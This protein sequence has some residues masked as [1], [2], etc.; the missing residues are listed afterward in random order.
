M[1]AHVTGKLLAYVVRFCT[2]TSPNGLFCA[3]AL[4]RFEDALRSPY[5]RNRQRRHDPQ[6]RG[7]TEGRR[8]P[9]ADAAL[10]RA[11]VP[12]PEPDAR[13]DA[14]GWTFWK[15]ASMRQEDEDEVRSRV[16]AHPVA[17]VF[18]EEARNG[19]DVPALIGAVAERCAIETADLEPFYRTLVERGLLVGEV[20]L[21]YNARRPLRMLAETARTAGCTPSWLGAVERIEAEVDTLQGSTAAAR[22]EAMQ[23]TTQ[24]LEALPHVRP[25]KPDDMFRADAASG[26]SVRLPRKI[27]GELREGLRPYVRMFS[28]FYPERIYRSAQAA[29]FLRT[30][31]PDTEVSLLDLYHGV[32][33]PE[34]KRRPVAFPDPGRV[35]VEGEGT[36]EAAEALARTREHFA[37]RAREAKPGEEIEITDGAMRSLVGDFPEPRWSSGVLFQLDTQD[38]N[39][40]TRGDYRLVLSALFQGTGL[41]LARFAHLHGEPVVRELKEGWSCLSRPGAVLAEMTYNHTYRTANAGLRPA[42]FEHEIE[43]PESAA[44]PARVLPLADLTVRWDTHQHGSPPARDGLEV[45]PASTAASTRW[46]LSF[47]VDI[48]CKDSSRSAFPGFEAGCHWPRVVSGTSSSSGLLGSQANG[49]PL[50]HARKTVCWRPVSGAAAMRCRA[51]CSSTLLRTPSRATWTSSLPSWSPSCCGASPRKRRPSCT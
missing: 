18:L 9:A 46:G 47:L 1:P 40:L 20:E 14:E 7:G 5:P 45:L 28:A 50:L 17:N 43:L 36:Q 37:Q 21:P 15:P 34:N 32:F 35:V 30:F 27:L 44:R 49:P 12:R 4:A 29:K 19:H 16:K 6:Y 39:A 51:T 8:L 41:A 31:P 11:T 38:P 42:I 2:K 23:R 10:D 48:G 13:E 22:R 26:L 25:L 24:T 3:T 33:E